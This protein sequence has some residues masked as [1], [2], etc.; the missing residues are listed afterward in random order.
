M[1]NYNITSKMLFDEVLDHDTYLRYTRPFPPLLNS[2]SRVLGLPC[3][4][5]TRKG[6]HDINVP[7]Q[8][9][10]GSILDYINLSTPQPVNGL[11]IDIHELS[12]IQSPYW[13]YEPFRVHELV[14]VWPTLDSIGDLSQTLL[15]GPLTPRAPE[16]APK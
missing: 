16:L 3:D 9:L 8:G 6:F 14:S 5:P 7:Y 10:H 4:A 2:S 12:S 13:Q 11:Q 1:D 15:N